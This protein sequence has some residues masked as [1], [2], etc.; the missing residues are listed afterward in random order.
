MAVLPDVL[1]DGGDELTLPQL[2]QH[3]QLDAVPGVLG[4]D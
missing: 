2:L 1:D 4:E 3:R